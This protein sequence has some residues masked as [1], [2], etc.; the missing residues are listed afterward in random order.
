MPNSLR[1]DRRAFLKGLGGV[2]LAL[3]VLEAMG[4]E[5]TDQIPRRFCAIYTANGMSLPKPEHDISEWSWFP[6]KGKDGAFEFGK[7]TEPLTPFRSRL[8]F[9]GGLHHPNGPK[10]DPHVCSDMWLTGAPLHNPKPGTYNSSGID[11]V[12]A[13]HTKQFCRQP[14]LVLSIDAGTGYLSRT[15]TI[16][17]NLDGRPIPAENNPAPRV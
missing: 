10:A 11:Q 1:L 9:M 13:L 8:S 2:A 3:P 6:T 5:V 16:S 14:S 17:Y 4:A 15:G 7:S 12:I